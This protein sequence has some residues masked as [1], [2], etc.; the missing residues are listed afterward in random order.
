MRSTHKTILTGAL[1]ALASAL[2][3]A[4]FL[5]ISHAYPYYFIWDMDLVAAEDVILVGSGLTPD[6]LNHP[7][8][9]MYLVQSLTARLA[10]GLG[11]LSALSLGQL[12]ASLNPAAAVAE[13]TTFLRLHS[14]YLELLLIIFLWASATLVLR[15]GRGLSLLF[16]VALGLQESFAFHS[17]MIRTELYAMVYWSAALCVVA[18]ARNWPPGSS[19]HCT[20]FPSPWSA[21][22]RSAW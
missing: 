13:L 2:F 17:A 10:H 16:L 19:G 6:H 5:A 21:A 9:G 8:F 12:D 3:L 4:R 22:R 20:T 18:L 14:P 15:P 7:C 11:V 1:A